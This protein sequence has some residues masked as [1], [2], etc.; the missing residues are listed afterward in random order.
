M[1][2]V[3]AAIV[4]NDRNEVL[5]AKRRPEK[6]LGGFWE[7]PG[8]KLEEGETKEE[9]LKREIYEELNLKI[10]VKREF[11][12]NICSY[13][14]GIINLHAFICEL[15][16]S[17]EIISTDHDV[18]IWV[19]VEQLKDYNFAPADVPIVSEFIGL[20]QKEVR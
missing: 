7:F 5:I 16:C 12:S 2:D 18:I 14:F 19:N 11:M 6:R 4:Q 17:N 13:E 15:N 8:G 20:F 3:V 10:M 1:V 9:A